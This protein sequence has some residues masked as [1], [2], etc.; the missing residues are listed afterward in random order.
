MLNYLPGMVE[1]DMHRNTL[2][3]HNDETVLARL[4]D[5]VDKNYLVTPAKTAEYLVY[6]VK[7]QQYGSGD[8][9]DFMKSDVQSSHL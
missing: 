1:T 3:T 9:V 5:A 6:V 2:E 8:Y 7:S 4:K